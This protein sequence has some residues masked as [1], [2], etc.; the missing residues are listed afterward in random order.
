MDIVSDILGVLLIVLVYIYV[1]GIP[2]SFILFLVMAL[3]QIPKV[4]RKERKPTKLIIFSILSSVSL[5]ALAIEIWIIVNLAN[6]VAH[7]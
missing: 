3:V 1:F 5:F 7:M 2:V 6:G 4:K